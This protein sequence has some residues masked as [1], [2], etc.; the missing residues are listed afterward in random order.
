VCPGSLWAE[1]AWPDTAGF[2]AA[3][4]TVFHRIA[5]EFLEAGVRPRLDGGPQTVIEN[6][7]SITVDEKMIAYAVEYF[8]WCIEEPGQ[9]YVEKRVDYSDLTPIPNQGGTCDFAACS[10]GL[11]VLKDAKYGVGVQVFAERNSQLML[12]AYGA[13]RAYDWLYDFHTFRLCICQPR[14]GHFD[15]WECSRAELL[16]FAASAKERMAACWQEDAPRVPG[17][18]QCRFCRDVGCVAR[19]AVQDHLID[20]TFGD[21]TITPA[22]S[23]RALVRLEAGETPHLP[24]IVAKSLETRHLA[25]ILDFRKVYE[26]AFADIAIELERRLTNGE[27]VTDWIGERWMIAVGR[28]SRSVADVDEVISLLG[29]IGVD[30]DD[31]YE[32][33]FLS[34]AKLE[35]KMVQT[36]LRKSAAAKILAPYIKITPGRPTLKQDKPGAEEA[37]DDLDMFENQ[38]NQ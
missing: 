10:M 25:R 31:L 15:T 32:R 4:G 27:V 22:E 9:H 13:F 35:E 19:I 21:E 18:S 12:Y 33:K 6:G 14:L 37:P 8:D 30:E 3:Q 29:I 38:E 23:N 20:Q 17:V 16:E 28:S 1:L 26:K 5:A 24:K 34:P 2:E 7:F 36:G 11:L